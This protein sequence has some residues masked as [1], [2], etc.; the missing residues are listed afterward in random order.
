[1]ASSIIPGN[2]E[3][4]V[5]GPGPVLG[6]CILGGKIIKEVIGIRLREECDTKIVDSKGKRCALI[7]VAPE[8]RGLATGKYW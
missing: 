2:C 3:P 5:A 4:K 1:V 7:S 8:T 6:E